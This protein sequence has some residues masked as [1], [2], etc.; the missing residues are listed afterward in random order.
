MIGTSLT[1]GDTSDPS[2]IVRALSEALEKSHARR[3]TDRVASVLMLLSEHWA[4]QTA[5]ACHL[6]MR[7]TR[8]LQL[9]GGVC[10]GVMVNGVIEHKRPA[11]AVAVIPERP[12]RL[13]KAELSIHL[14]QTEPADPLAH[15]DM[16]ANDEGNRHALGLLSYGMNRALF[17]TI[18]HGHVSQ[19]G[20]S[21][22]GMF[23]HRIQTFDSLGLE[24]IGPW[25][26]V[27]SAQGNTLL[28][29]DGKPATK[30]LLCP[31][32]NTHP[33]ALRLGVKRSGMVDWLPVI[34]LHGDGSIS[35]PSAIAPGDEICLAARTA[36]KARLE[37]MQWAERLTPAFK[38]ST[39]RLMIV[40][41]GMERSTLCHFE[42]PEWDVLKQQWPDTPMI[43]G[44]GQAVWVRSPDLCRST[45]KQALNHR[46]AASFLCF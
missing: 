26:H 28:T 30:A 13:H 46:L 29:V 41:G 35:L 32:D 34:D 37:V 21:Q 14:A 39:R 45:P 27:E 43:G 6:A 42:D 36:D 2:L 20:G 5:E 11:V 33:V 18:Q 1:V 4:P 15:E 8:S 23:A 24:Q 3:H 16:A 19:G 31:P 22:L 9:W 38:S 10:K 17:P 25:R 12:E 44:L 40:M 7:Q